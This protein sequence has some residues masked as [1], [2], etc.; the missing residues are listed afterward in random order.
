MITR[1]WGCWKRIRGEL[2]KTVPNAEANRHFWID[3]FNVANRIVWQF[4]FMAAPMCLVVRRAE[5]SGRLEI[6]SAF[7]VS[8]VQNG[9]DC[10]STAET[11]KAQRGRAAN[12]IRAAARL[13]LVRSCWSLKYLLCDRPSSAVDS[14][15]PSWKPQRGDEHSAAEPQPTSFN[16]QPKAPARTVAAPSRR[17]PRAGTRLGVKQMRAK[18]A[19]SD[20]LTV[21]RLMPA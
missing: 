14:D 3:M 21:Q 6:L 7:R 20:R 19:D 1:P 8:A 10:E 18:R 5:P 9:F 13:A 4:S 11:R 17:H 15:H 12:Q 2:Q 16:A